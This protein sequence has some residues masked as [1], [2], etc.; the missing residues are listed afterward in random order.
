MNSR[1]FR[2]A[3]RL[4]SQL[5]LHEE[6]QRSPSPAS[7]SFLTSP[8]SPSLSLSSSSLSS[9]KSSLASPRS[10]SDANSPS[11]SPIFF[12]YLSPLE[13]NSPATSPKSKS[14]KY[15]LFP[16]RTQISTCTVTRIGSKS[17]SQCS[18]QKFHSIDGGSTGG[19]ATLKNDGEQKKVAFGIT[20]KV[21]TISSG[22]NM[23]QT[24]RSIYSISSSSSSS[25]DSSDNEE[26]VVGFRT[27][28]SCNIPTRKLC[29]PVEDGEEFRLMGNARGEHATV[30][31]TNDSKTIYNYSKTNVNISRKSTCL[32]VASKERDKKTNEEASTNSSRRPLVTLTLTTN[33]I[34]EDIKY[35]R[36]KPTS[37]SKQCIPSATAKVQANSNKSTGV[38]GIKKNNASNANKTYSYRE[39]PKYF[40]YSYTGDSSK[41]IPLAKLANSKS[42]SS[43]KSSS[44]NS[45]GKS[46][47]KSV[48]SKSL[49]SKSVANNKGCN[50][51]KSSS[52]SSRLSSNKR[53]IS[54]KGV[55]SSSSIKSSSSNKSIVSTSSGSSVK[56]CSSSASASSYKSAMSSQNYSSTG[57]EISKTSV[58][59]TGISKIASSKPL[60][61]KCSI[62]QLKNNETTSSKL[63]S[64]TSSK[65]EQPSVA[66]RFDS[67]FS[68]SPTPMYNSLESN[69]S[70]KYDTLS[71]KSSRE[72]SLSRDLDVSSCSSS[73]ASTI[74][75]RSYRSLIPASFRSG[76][77]N[78]YKHSIDR[79]KVTSNSNGESSCASGKSKIDRKDG[80]S[81]VAKASEKGMSIGKDI[82]EKAIKGNRNKSSKI[83]K[84]IKAV[85][86]NEFEEKE[87][88]NN[89]PVKKAKQENENRKSNSILKRKIFSGRQYCRLK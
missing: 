19:Y 13:T 2:G 61:K 42:N 16:P 27:A 86:W 64:T 47:T 52:S 5:E 65:K 11:K 26:D 33:T 6:L 58:T 36:T 23:T 78:K 34:E 4:L 66:L 49:S 25:S 39:N 38:S 68:K 41:E 67:V 53:C 60:I 74:T 29:E 71:S 8:S 85:R 69:S 50:L 30:I 89:T 56:S 81:S 77:K 82:L 54:S 73:S 17:P 75:V 51:P 80:R 59:T 63:P 7:S 10:M 28:V 76:D 20:N 21:I 32:D 3:Q 45:S 40:F 9:F 87:D 22:E 1:C 12:G 48:S 57:I 31:I 88:N 72:G 43:L 15:H 55:N 70:L 24:G 84:G 62:S 83:G 46:L 37:L 18:S 14:P 44:K 79:A 35:D